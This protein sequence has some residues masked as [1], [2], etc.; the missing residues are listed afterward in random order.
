MDLRTCVTNRVVART[1]KVA[2]AVAAALLFGVPHAYAQ[3]TRMPGVVDR[4]GQGLPGDFDE[5]KAGGTGLSA[6]EYQGAATGNEPIATIRRVEFTGDLVLDEQ[7]LQRAVAAYLDKPLTGRDLSE[8]KYEITSLYFT[9]GYPL[10]KVVTPPQKL[11]EGV[12]KIRIYMG[13]VGGTEVENSVG[14]SAAVVEAMGQRL[15]KG[16]VFDERVAESVLQDLNDLKNVSARLNLRAGQEKGTTDLRLYLSEADED[17]Q[18]VSLDNCGSD[19]TGKLVLTGEFEKSN[20]MGLGETLGLTLRKSDEDL[21]SAM[22]S[23]ETP[24]GLGNAKLEA[25]YLHSENEI[26]DYLAALQASGESD[27]FNIAVSSNLLNM[28]REKATVRVGLQQRTHES[29]LAGVKESE[30]NITRVYAEGSYLKRTERSVLYTSLRLGKG[31]SWLGADDT[32]EADATRSTGNPRAWI[33]NASLVGRFKVAERDNLMLTM[34]AQKASDDLL[35]SDLLSVGGYYS[36]RGFQPAETTGEH[37]VTLSLEYN[38]NY[39]PV[40]GWDVKVSPFVDLGHVSN[41]V[42]GSVTDSTLKS[43][44]IGAEFNRDWGG[45]SSTRVRIDLAHPVGDYDSTTVDDNTIYASL[46]QTF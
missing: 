9:E 25:N 26:G 3:E 22:I 13:R 2:V 6:P 1:S 39:A 32:G 16:E 8:L 33:M 31:G 24:I 38:H 37:G 18:R 44:G 28:R 15:E 41:N 45:Q 10:V 34:Q 42:A 30:D 20:L 46:T 23:L 11:G 5:E 7:V 14:L 4:P 12:L 36:V 35:S 40:N 27:I 19:L 43:I 21:T 17:V 29:F